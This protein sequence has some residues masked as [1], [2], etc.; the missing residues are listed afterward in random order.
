MFV[1]FLITVNAVPLND[2]NN[3]RRTAQSLIHAYLP[4][5]RN[6]IQASSMFLLFLL[7][8]LLNFFN[9]F[10]YKPLTLSALAGGLIVLAYIAM[11]QD[12]LEEGQDK[13]RMYVSN[14]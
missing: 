14:Y 5:K 11:T 1:S 7:I 9:R 12:V 10:F 8:Q 4:F 13:R 2:S 3:T 6:M